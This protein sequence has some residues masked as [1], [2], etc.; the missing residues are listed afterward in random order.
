MGC[1]RFQRQQSRRDATASGFAFVPHPCRMRTQ[2][3]WAVGRYLH[4]PTELFCQALMALLGR[5]FGAVGNGGV[6]P[7]VDP[8]ANH[9]RLYGG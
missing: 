2:H 6:Y 8:T 5:G 9:S 4:G 3:V 7:S 1:L